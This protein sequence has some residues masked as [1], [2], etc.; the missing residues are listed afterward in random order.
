MKE[1][2]ACRVVLGVPELFFQVKEHSSSLAP[3]VEK[4]HSGVARNVGCSLDR[5]A[6]LSVG[7]LVHRS[8]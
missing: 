5:I 2:S 1:L 7:N 6:A 3:I 4:L 8:S